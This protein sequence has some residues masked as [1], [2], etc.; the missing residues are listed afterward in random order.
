MTAYDAGV[1]RS[2]RTNEPTMPVVRDKVDAVWSGEVRDIV[3]FPKGPL[4]PL[5]SPVI[6]P[7]PAR[8]WTVTPVRVSPPESSNE[9]WVVIEPTL[10]TRKS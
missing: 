4:G 2:G 6:E 9:T 8:S 5:I 10:R 1:K 7:S 3:A